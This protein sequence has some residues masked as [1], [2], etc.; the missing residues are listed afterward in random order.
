MDFRDNA[1]VRTPVMVDR[2]QT[3]S[4]KTVKAFSEKVDPAFDQPDSGRGVVIY[5]RV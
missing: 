2:E 1:F 3:K 5:H 4:G